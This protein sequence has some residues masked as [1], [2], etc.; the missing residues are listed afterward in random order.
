VPINCYGFGCAKLYIEQYY[1]FADINFSFTFT[2]N[3]RFTY[4]GTGTYSFQGDDDVWVFINGLLTVDLG[5]VHP[6]QAASIDLTYPE[7]GCPEGDLTSYLPC[8]T[9]DTNHTTY[10]CACMLGLVK[11]NKQTTKQF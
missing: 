2:L 7:G 9:K 8:A 1:Y 10:P 4:Q 6:A 5:G 11:G 3:L